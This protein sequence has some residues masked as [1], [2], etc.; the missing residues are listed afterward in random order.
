MARDGSGRHPLPPLRWSS[1]SWGE[2]YRSLVFLAQFNR[3][4]PQFAHESSPTPPG[5]NVLRRT[6][7]AQ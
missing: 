2:L 7:A 6:R 1:A 4:V 3:L 5:G